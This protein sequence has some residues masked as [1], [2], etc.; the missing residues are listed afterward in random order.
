MKPTNVIDM[1]RTGD[2]GGQKVAMKFDENSIAHI[3]SVLTDLYSDPELAVIREYSTNARDSHIASGQTRPIEI[4][5]PNGMSPF[6]KIR[7]FGT[8]ISVQDISDI[9][10]KYGASTKRNSDTQTGMLGLG[11]KSALTYT[12]Q[13][14]IVSVKNNV[15]V[16][17]VVSRIEDGTGVMEIVDTVTTNEANGVEISIPV[18]PANHFLRKAVHFFSFWDEGTVLING[19]QA[20][21]VTLTKV[22]DS[23][24]IGQ[25]L[26]SDFI[27]MG[28]VPYPV[29]G[30]GLYTAR[31]PYSDPFN[32]VAFV[33]IG[34]VNFTPS[35]EALAYTKRTEATVVN[36]RAEVLTHLR[37]SAQKEIDAAA[38]PSE[39]FTVFS[40]WQNRMGSTVIPQ[41]TKYRDVVIPASF[42]FPQTYTVWHSNY[43]RGQIRTGYQTIDHANLHNNM[44]I[45]DYDD[46]KITPRHKEKIRQWKNVNGV[47]ASQHFFT[48]DNP[49][50]FWLTPKQIVSWAT[51]KAVVI[52]SAGSG[53]KS[54][55]QYS[56]F[57]I[58]GYPRK[59]TDLDKTKQYLYVGTRSGLNA[60]SI[61]GFY[62]SFPTI[63]IVSL[64]EN[65]VEKF[66]REN[67]TSISLSRFVEKQIT[68][69]RDVLND[70]DRKV[71]G[72]DT[73]ERQTLK[74][75]DP[76]RITDPDL[77][78]AINIAKGMVSTA[79][80]VA[81]TKITQAARL[82]NIHAADLRTSSALTGY[83][84]I[85]NANRGTLSQEHI[86]IYINAVYEH[87]KSAAANTK[88]N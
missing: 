64:S 5:L 23:I 7:D 80:A 62:A 15:K 43:S 29:E 12:S 40:Q 14:T 37:Q 6:F 38:T 56:T 45:V 19:E 35:R 18:K 63:C 76:S 13:F 78:D 67:P 46:I 50:A 42:A 4:T 48:K 33:D 10:S 86:Y 85:G 9:Y 36:L 3:M 47:S 82:V 88:E 11:C 68:V 16:T 52:A 21:R 53:T 70:R 26:G 17:V 75:M 34:A 61:K 73:Y 57:G 55:P 32:V 58:D 8:G 25:N 39:A 81:Y 1:T 27:V 49:A 30:G 71:L 22:T 74:S 24:G 51:I 72:I 79:N 69:V 28:G 65:R 84:L 31:R 20:K 66:V 44:I 83:P 54:V 87:N 60:N 41:G 2:L 77:V 59:V